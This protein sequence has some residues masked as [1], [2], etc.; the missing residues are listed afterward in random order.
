[1]MA[2][3]TLYFI[4]T[5]VRRRGQRNFTSDG[6]DFEKE[7]FAKTFWALREIY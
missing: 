4:A 1:M 2:G 3:L 6:V 7:K 5:F